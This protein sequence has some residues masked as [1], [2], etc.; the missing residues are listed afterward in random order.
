MKFIQKNAGL[1]RSVRSW[2]VLGLVLALAVV[3]SVYEQTVAL[4]YPAN[5]VK[6]WEAALPPYTYTLPSNKCNLVALVAYD[7]GITIDPRS[8]YLV[9]F[10][11]MPGHVYQG[12]SLSGTNGEANFSVLRGGT[13]VTFFVAEVQSWIGLLVSN[14]I[15]CGARYPGD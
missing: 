6:L 11:Q 10:Y 14:Q 1:L 9:K 8:N 3:A 7:N 2:G 4:P 12:Q 13:V 15:A 5:T